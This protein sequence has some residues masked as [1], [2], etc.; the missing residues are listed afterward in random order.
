MQQNRYR[1]NKKHGIEPAWLK[2]EKENQ[3]NSNSV[4]QIDEETQRAIDVFQKK[5]REYKNEK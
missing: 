1:N 3:K 5:L 4:D 2:S